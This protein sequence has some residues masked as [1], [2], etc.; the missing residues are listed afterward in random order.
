MQPAS[1]YQREW[2]AEIA[3]DFELRGDRTRLVKNRHLGPLRVLK[4]FYP[5]RHGGCHVYVLHP[6]GGLVVGDQVNVSV[7]CRPHS[8]VLLTTPSA[9]KIYT[10]RELPEPQRQ[11]VFLQ[12][13]EHACLEWLPQ[14]TIV[15]SGGNA[16]F[17]TKIEL[18]ENSKL[19]AWDIMCL[20][21]PA[22]NEVFA[23]G[24]CLQSLEIYCAG[25]LQLLERNR[26]IAGEKSMRA[27]WGC[28]G[29]STLGTLVTTTVVSR[30][31]QDSL[32]EELAK[33]GLP[34]L[35]G[36]TQRDEF[37][38][39]RYIGNSGEICRAGFELV[40]RTLR[41]EFNQQQA[42]EPRIWRT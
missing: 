19:F 10:A 39:A 20:G 5:E 7:T 23:A 1:T 42:C 9:G 21:R 30:D 15:F 14:E 17:T 28:H 40:W 18:A 37:F 24:R 25:V 11:D 6:P 38:I 12:V 35:W 34:H 41:P 27:A 31:R 13:D 29:A 33:F 4:P 2:L 32:Y 36:L 3:L 22:A 8:N 26:Y 16:Q